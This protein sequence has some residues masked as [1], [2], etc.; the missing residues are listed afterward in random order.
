NAG[1]PPARGASGR[2]MEMNTIGKI[3]VILNFVFALVVGGFLVIDFATR[4]NWKTA[5]DTLKREMDVLKASRESSGIALQK[6]VNDTKKVITENEELRQTLKDKED[7]NKAT[8]TKYVADIE[9]WK[10]KFKGK[11]QLLEKT[12]AEQDRLRKEL[13]D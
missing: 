12:V 11:E 9:E 6:V 4:T 7:L 10:L 5:Y 13:V 3:L 1:D 8:E 2:G